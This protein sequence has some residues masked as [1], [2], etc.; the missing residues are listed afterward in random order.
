MS[1]C[2][3]GRCLRDRC[4]RDT[5][6]PASIGLAARAPTR[7]FKL[8]ESLYS[9]PIK[10]QVIFRNHNPRQNCLKLYFFFNTKET[11]R[12]K[13]TPSST[14]A[15][16]ISKL[17]SKSIFVNLP[18]Q[19]LPKIPQWIRTYPLS[20]TYFSQSAFGCE[21]RLYATQSLHA[22]GVMTAAYD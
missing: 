22:V 12:T 2:V 10:A 6:Q 1:E 9:Q 19:E 11:F 15:F 20:K 5:G 13:T 14:I 3:D 17:L 21:R 16:N 7:R 18:T 4:R 8:S